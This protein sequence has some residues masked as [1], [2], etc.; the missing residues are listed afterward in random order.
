[1]KGKGDRWAMAKGVY[2]HTYTLSS[3]AKT[4]DTF[5]CM[6]ETHTHTHTHTQVNSS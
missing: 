3:R 1:M 4:G 5:R 2:I 6:F